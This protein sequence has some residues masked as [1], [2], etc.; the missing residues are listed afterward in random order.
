[1][2]PPV[3]VR[4]FKA[5]GLGLLVVATVAGMVALA[6]HQ[7]WLTRVEQRAVIDSSDQNGIK[8]V[9]K[10]PIQGKAPAISVN[11]GDPDAAWKAAM[12][13]QLAE[14]EIKLSDHEM[15]IKVLEGLAKVH[16]QMTPSTA[17]PVPKPPQYRSMQFVSQKVE[18][19][20]VDDPET[21]LLA[22]GATK[23]SFT[24]ESSMNSDVESVWTGIIRANVC[25]TATGSELLI[26][27]GST[28][29][30]RYRSEKL[31][32]GDQRLPTFAMSVALPNGRS[33]ELGDAPVMDQK[34]QAGLAS[35][36]DQHYW[37]LASAIVLMGVLRGGQQA[38][39]Y[40]IAANDPAA[41]IASGMAS[42][43]SQ[44]GQMRIGPA[45]NTRP[46]I[47]VDAGEP[48]VVILT[49]PLKLSPYPPAI[50]GRPSACTV[51]VAR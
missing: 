46:T 27:Q 1:M 11:G 21:H 47:Y 34:G 29:L 7:G 50:P 49:K 23:L 18:S 48:G 28:L 4:L 10:H 25:D 26:P 14:H 24:V 22:P 35:S 31:L 2:Q 32:F 17:K 42:S 33:V 30:G 19:R 16:P 39:Q 13:Q 38:I 44:V 8:S 40:Q 12:R 41:A 3:R 37:R 9:I 6:V 51:G 20:P 15:R 5:V 36:V 43:A 45:L